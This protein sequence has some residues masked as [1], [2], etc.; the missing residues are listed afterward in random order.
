MLVFLFILFLPGIQPDYDRVS[1][2]VDELGSA[3]RKSILVKKVDAAMTLIKADDTL[4]VY[5]LKVK[6]G[7]TLQLFQHAGSKVD[8][9][10]L[11]D[12]KINV[13]LQ[14][15]PLV[16]A[17]MNPH[18]LSSNSVHAY[19]LK[20]RGSHYLMVLAN[21]AGASG[22]AINNTLFYFFNLTHDQKPTVISATSIYGTTANVAD[23]NQDGLIDIF[24]VRELNDKYSIESFNIFPH[25]AV[26]IKGTKQIIL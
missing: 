10:K 15:S 16:D 5:N 8:I 24:L 2:K 21:A 22:K 17:N 7:V 4:S 13:G 11:N 3:S 12:C 14:V 19:E 6:E 9:L 25:K 18:Y 26:K 23:V 20:Y 1:K